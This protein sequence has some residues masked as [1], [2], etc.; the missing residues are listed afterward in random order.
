[1]Q[2]GTN[3]PL[4]LTSVHF[5]SPDKAK[6][7]HHIE[8]GIVQGHNDISSKIGGTKALTWLRLDRN[9]PTV[10]IRLRMGAYLS[11]TN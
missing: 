5:D 9:P 2:Q 11:P 8:C 4:I 10:T 1:M 7:R 6:T 3:S